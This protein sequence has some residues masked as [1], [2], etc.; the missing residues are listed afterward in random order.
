MVP[1][2]GLY[3]VLVNLNVR[4]YSDI[5]LKFSIMINNKTEAITKTTK[6]ESQGTNTIIL[7][8]ILNLK[9]NEIISITISNPASSYTTN[10]RVVSSSKFFVFSKGV[11]SHSVPALSTHYKSTS[12]KLPANTF[13]QLNDW[14]VTSKPSLDHYSNVQLQQGEFVA[15]QPGIYQIN[16]ALYLSNCSSSAVARLSLKRDNNCTAISPDITLTKESNDCYLENS[17]VLNLDTNDT[18]RLQV[19][20]DMKYTVLS[21]TSYQVVLQTKYSLWPAAI[22]QLGEFQFNTNSPAAK[23]RLIKSTLD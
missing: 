14:D 8:G 4:R 5:L 21:Q 16:I 19:K 7:E 11:L 23:V 12:T 13:S 15:P 18:L 17:L 10:I 3:H 6:I 2:N 9:E 1:H 20:S 22:F